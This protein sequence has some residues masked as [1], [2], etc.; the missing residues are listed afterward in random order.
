MKNRDWVFVSRIQLVK[1][2][3]AAERLKT[4][5]TCEWDAKSQGV[6]LPR[7]STAHS[8]AV[9]LG[10]QIYDSQTPIQDGTYDREGLVK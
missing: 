5:K 6:Y 7:N 3:S 8:L 9:L 10:L 4:V 1:N 2:P